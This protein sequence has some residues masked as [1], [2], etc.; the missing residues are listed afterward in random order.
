MSVRVEKLTKR[1]TEKGTPAVNDVSFEAPAG[2]ITSLLGPSGAGKSTVL[3]V[4]AGL[5]LPDS[6]HIFIGEQNVSQTSVQN[7]GVG[8]V[9]QNYAL[10]Q[11]MTVF[12][13]IAFGLD[14]RKRPRG[15]IKDRVE[16]LLRLVQLE[17]LA[18]RY[19]N[20]LSGGQRQR[21]AFARAL[22]IKP[23]VLLLD[24]PFGALDARVRI[25]LRE[26]LERLHDEMQVTTLLVTHDQAEAL[27]VS[28]H[29]VVMADG[30]VI[31]AGSPTE[32]YD[33]PATPEAATFLGANLLRGRIKGGRTEIG[34]LSVHAPSDAREGAEAMA[35]VRSHDLQLALPTEASAHLSLARVVRARRVGGFTKVVVEM[36]AGDH[37]TLDLA[38]DDFDKLG[39]AAGDR[40]LVNVRA[41]NVFLVDY[42][43]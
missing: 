17:D 19:P 14:I 23:R 18:R 30:K 41:A 33:H 8:L 26:W 4:V 10:F 35:F 34:S 43:I 6:G 25:E 37:V 11:H 42:E 7:R 21:V 40:V 5:E 3:R 39:I 20:Q 28:Q 22:A 31:Q 9:F 12:D 27:E 29:V 16:E 32:V 38:R 24:E 15:E 1:F 36:A 2:A 13:N